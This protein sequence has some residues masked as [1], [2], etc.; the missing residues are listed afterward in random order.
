MLPRRSPTVA[1]TLLESE[2][3]GHARGAFT[4]AVSDRKGI[5]EQGGRGT[6]LLDEIGDT[7]PALQV[8]LLRVLEEHEV[9]PIGAQRAIPVH[10][11]VIA[12]TNAALEKAVSDG[13]FR[14]DLY[15]RLSVIVIC[16]PSL[17]L[18]QTGDRCPTTP[19][20]WVTEIDI[21]DCRFQIADWIN[22]PTNLRQRAINE[23]SGTQPT[24]DERAAR[25]PRPYRSPNLTSARA[26][27]V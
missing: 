3:F 4:G 6:I 9:R 23:C 22:S 14:Q 27:Y 24:S 25:R 2:M 17:T 10:A 20:L 26:A 5:F 13:T 12:S 1:E 11:R 16:R 19:A 15:Y 18:S 7:S 21:S 8:K